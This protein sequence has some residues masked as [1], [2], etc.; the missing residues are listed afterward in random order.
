[1]SLTLYHHKGACSLAPLIVL[2]ESRLDYTLSI[3]NLA[4]RA[5]YLRVNPAGKVP[6]LTIGD[7]LLTE[8]LA[9]L[10][11]VAALAPEAGLFPASAELA[12]R[13]LSLMAWFGSTVHILRRQ[14]R[15]PLRFTPDVEAQARLVEA[16]RPKMWEAL[17]EMQARLGGADW[18]GGAGFS[19][20]DA[21]GLVFY[22]WGLN[23]GFDMASLA[24]LSA[25][26]DRMLARPAVALAVS[27]D[28]GVLHDQLM[29]TSR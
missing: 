27:Q 10:Y 20:A 26:K 7:E 17:V 5:D 9:I 22:G 15:M 18:Y 8:N 2:E 23:D 13:A 19:V 21:Y 11:R 14:I 4:D 28:A 16:G 3:V 12:S 25:W 29:G 1:M 24:Q 6:A